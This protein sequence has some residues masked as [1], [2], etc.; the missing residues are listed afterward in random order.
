MA[1]GPLAGPPLWPVAIRSESDGCLRRSPRQNRPRASRPETLASVSP[2][3]SVSPARG[4][5]EGIEPLPVGPAPAVPRRRRRCVPRLGGLPLSSF[6]YFDLFPT[7]VRLGIGRGGRRPV[8]SV[9]AT[10]AT[11]HGSGR[12]QRTLPLKGTFPFR[13]W[14]RR[15]P[16]C[17]SSSS[18]ASIGC[19]WRS[20]GTGAAGDGGALCRRARGSSGECSILFPFPLF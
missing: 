4:G 8:V 9:E 14:W 1:Y 16:H 11:S 12:R 2:T 17:P 3:R 5:C 13:P 19:A 18:H 7:H 10:P 6:F 15:A 20:S